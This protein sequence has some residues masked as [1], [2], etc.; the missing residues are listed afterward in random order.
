MYP[1][2]T[3][4]SC[5]PLCY[6][7]NSTEFATGRASAVEIRGRGWGGIPHKL[8]DSFSTKITQVKT[9]CGCGC[10][11]MA[12]LVIFRNLDKI[13]IWNFDSRIHPSSA[14]APSRTLYGYQITDMYHHDDRICQIIA[15]ALQS[16]N[17]VDLEAEP[18]LTGSHFHKALRERAFHVKRARMY[19]D[20]PWTEY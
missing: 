13:L 6:P 5:S 9:G 14:T 16:L 19:Q 12:S 2:S 15:I 10:W 1:F 3:S 17:Y 4:G 11:L 20:R 8:D 7:A 18:N